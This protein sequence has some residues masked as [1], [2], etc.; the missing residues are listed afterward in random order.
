MARRTKLVVVTFMLA[1]VLAGSALAEGVWT[2]YISGALTGFESRIWK[3]NN[4]DNVATVIRFQGCTR[5]PGIGT[6][7]SVNLRRVISLWPDENKGTKT[8][9]CAT[10]ASGNWGD[11]NGGD[12]RFKITKI[13]GSES[14]YR[15]WVDHVRVQY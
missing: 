3:D 1:F 6:N 7:T 11:V 14:G 15:L 5:A 8:L 4:N 2:S 13:N 9:Y 12:Y 10:S